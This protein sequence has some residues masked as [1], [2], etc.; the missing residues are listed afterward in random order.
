LM[1][2]SLIYFQDYFRHYIVFV[3]LIFLQWKNCTEDL[4]KICFDR[5]N[6]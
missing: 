1:L 4:Q 3:V 2:F 5:L 6:K